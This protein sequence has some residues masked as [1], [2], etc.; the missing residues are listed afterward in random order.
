MLT[1]REKT[2]YNCFLRAGRVA[3]NKPYT[4]RRNFDNVSDEM[5]ILLK[6]LASF[7]HRNKT[8]NPDDFFAAP[9]RVYDDGNESYFDLR[10]YTTRRALKCYSMYMKSRETQNPD[11][12]EVISRCK[13]CCAN[14]YRYCNEHNITLDDYKTLTVSSTPVVIQ[15]LKSHI[16]NFY[17]LHGLDCSK[18]I[19]QI[20]ANLL[21]FLIPD[22][23]ILI[24]DTRV[25]FSKSARLKHVIRKSLDIIDRELTN[26]KQQTTNNKQ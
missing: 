23:N 20:D 16:I 17:V 14:I 13:E 2:T 22:Y 1:E 4:I 7:F 21:D 18:K 6:K 26:N 10:F 9:Y 24:H 11:S 8:V 5:Y 3:K 19:Q 15:H 25:E 12:D